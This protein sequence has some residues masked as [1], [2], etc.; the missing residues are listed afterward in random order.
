MLSAAQALDF[1]LKDLVAPNTKSGTA[2]NPQI[3]PLTMR[4]PF[5]ESLFEM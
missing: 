4:S 3:I 5:V 1:I 2:K